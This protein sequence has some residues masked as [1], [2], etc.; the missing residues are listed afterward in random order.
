VQGRG[1]TETE[2]RTSANVAL[3][4][5]TV[6]RELFPDLPPGAS[7]VGQVLRVQRQVVEVV[8]VLQAKG[9]GFGGQD[10]DDVMVLPVTTVQR[11][12]AG[13]PFP[14][15]VSMGMVRVAPEADKAAVDQQITLL[16]RQ[17]HRLA[18][19]VDNDFSVRDLSAL[20]ASLAVV[21]Q[22]LSVLLGS[23][24]FISLLV[25]GIGVMNIMLVSV[26]E[27]TREIGLRMALGAS[28][29]LIATQFLLEA[30]WL[31]AVGAAIGLA[32]GVGLGLAITATGAVTAVFSTWSL[33]LSTAVALAVGLGFGFW[34]AQRAAQLAPAEALR[35]A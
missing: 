2:S 32:V 28:P 13:T 8:G 12:L 15:A 29:G 27:R 7:P 14:G 19:G 22:V 11:R 3:L 24:A 26:T 20:S 31:S 9:Q 33:G 30:A 16:L 35:A 17:R 10:Q 4:G 5:A 6:V 21:S 25:G 34:P 1:F 23:I 18:D